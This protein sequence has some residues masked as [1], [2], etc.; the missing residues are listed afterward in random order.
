MLIV[1]QESRA[2]SSAPLGVPAPYTGPARDQ[3]TLAFEVLKKAED[4]KYGSGHNSLMFETQSFTTYLLYLLRHYQPCSYKR[5]QRG[6]IAVP[7]SQLQIS[8]GPVLFR[9]ASRRAAK[10]VLVHLEHLLPFHWTSP[11]RA[12][13]HHSRSLQQSTTKPTLLRPNLEI[14]S[15]F[16]Y[17]T[18]RLERIHRR[19]DYQPSL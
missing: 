11:H 18:R 3:D 6:N 4:R 16:S 5:T 14:G 10:P 8:R 2:T 7:D 13:V 9:C 17:K 15:R 19:L 12:T 1:E